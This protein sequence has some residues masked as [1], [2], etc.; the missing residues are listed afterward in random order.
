VGDE[1][2]LWHLELGYAAAMRSDLGA[3]VDRRLAEL[4]IVRLRRS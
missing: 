1:L 4:I 2:Q 3:A